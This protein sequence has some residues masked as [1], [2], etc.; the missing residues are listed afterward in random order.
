[1]QKHPAFFRTLDERHQN[2]QTLSDSFRSMDAMRRLHVVVD[3]SR[4]M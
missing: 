2:F 1:M 4:L 3:D